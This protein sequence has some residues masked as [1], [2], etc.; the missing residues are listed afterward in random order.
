MEL[1][2]NDRER[3]DRGAALLD[4]K[5][6]N[7]FTKINPAILDVDSFSLCPICQSTGL[8]FWDGVKE[9]GIGVS[10]GRASEYGF[11]PSESLEDSKEAEALSKAKTDYW[12]ELIARRLGGAK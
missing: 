1:T 12:L 4:E 9:L 10:D 8:S 6:P 11:Y 5:V 2:Q 7:W 3:I